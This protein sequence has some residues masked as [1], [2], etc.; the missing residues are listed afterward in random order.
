[1][2]RSGS[3]KTKAVTTPLLAV[4]IALVVAGGTPHRASAQSSAGTAGAEGANLPRALAALGEGSP[5]AAAS[6]GTTSAKPAAP[7]LRKMESEPTAKKPRDWL[8]YVQILFGPF[9]ALGS[10]VVGLLWGL[11]SWRLT[12]FTK[13]WSNL[14]QF[15]QKEARFM[16]PEKT[17]DYKSKFLDEDAVKYEMIARLCIGYLDDLYFLRSERE[18]QRW[19]RGSIRLFAGRHKAWL[20]DN[21]DS[22]DPG[23]YTFILRQL[24]QLEKAGEPAVHA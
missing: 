17:K 21:R 18:I 6:A 5:S 10:L 24:E 12:Y 13:E 16:D 8:D 3:Q 14:V 4:L 15:L 9:V 2:R 20:K 1:M 22:Y 19:F 7:L 23:F 11:R